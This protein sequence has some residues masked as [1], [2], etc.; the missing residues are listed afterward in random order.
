M[1]RKS[2]LLWVAAV[3]ITLA[4]AYYQRTTGP[5]YKLRGKTSFAG[6]KIRFELPRSWDAGDAEVRIKAPNATTTG[7][8]RYKRFNTDDEWT[9]FS[10]AREDGELVGYLPHQP[11]AGKL[12]YHVALVDGEESVL[13]NDDPAVIRFTGV[14]PMWVLIPHVLVMFTAMMMSMRTGMEALFRRKSSYPYAW[15]TLVTLVVGGLILGPLVQKYA[16]GAYWTGW[17]FGNDLTDNKTLV[18]VI[19]WAIAVWRLK[20][21]PEDKVW[22]V[23]AA[24]VLLIVYLIPHSALGSELDYSSGEITTG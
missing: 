3:I 12:A 9:S 19:F 1:K 8:I 22:P 20:K 16:F 21:N 15:I 5:T 14:V 6:E 7:M 24:A 10:M 11:P 2:A 23:V 18:G 4:S 17:P 13:L